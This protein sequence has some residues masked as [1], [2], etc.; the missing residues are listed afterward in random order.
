MSKILLFGAA[1][2]FVLYNWIVNNN[3]IENLQGAWIEE[4]RE[5]QPYKKYPPCYD[6]CGATRNVYNI[7]EQKGVT[8]DYNKLLNAYSIVLCQEKFGEKCR[9]DMLGQRISDLK[10]LGGREDH[11]SVEVVKKYV[12]TLRDNKIKTLLVLATSVVTQEL[13]KM[14]K[15]A[16]LTMKEKLQLL[17]MNE[18]F[19]DVHYDITN[20]LCKRIIN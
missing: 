17:K 5:N 19:L 10:A 9:K 11:S 1:A 3:Y 15:D 2:A 13:Y 14:Q 8:A 7:L 16:R 4:S 20:E 18:T 6:I 12:K